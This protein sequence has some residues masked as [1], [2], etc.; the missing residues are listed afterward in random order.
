MMRATAIVR[1]EFNRVQ[2]FGT[3]Q[4]RTRN[5]HEVVDWHTIRMRRQRCELAQQFSAIG[6]LFAHADDAAAAGFHA[7][8]AH[9]LKRVET[10]FVS[11]GGDDLAVE[12]RRGIDVV[13]V[14]IKACASARPLRLIFA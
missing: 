2:F 14:V 1:I 6:F 13:V 9:V 12:L 3:G 10:I 5:L 8:L 7:G 11:A 4:R